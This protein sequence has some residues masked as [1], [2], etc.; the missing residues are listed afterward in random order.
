MD[1]GKFQ[2]SRE[3]FNVFHP[4]SQLIRQ[5]LENP[6]LMGLISSD[7]LLDP[8]EKAILKTMEIVKSKDL[9]VTAATISDLLSQAQDGQIAVEY[10]S[11]IMRA[12]YERQLDGEYLARVALER[13]N[14]SVLTKGYV[15]LG[16]ALRSKEYTSEEMANHFNDEIMIKMVSSTRSEDSAAAVER[17]YQQITDLQNGVVVPYWRTGS[18]KFDQIVAIGPHKIIMVAAAKKIGKSRFVIDRAMRLLNVNKGLSVVWFTFEMRPEEVIMNQIAWQT[19][20][21]TRKLQG[22]LGKMSESEI[23]MISETKAWI[24]D[25]PIRWI[26]QRRTMDQIEKDLNKW[27]KGPTMVIIDNLGLIEIPTGMN[28]IQSDDLIAKRMVN[29]RDSMDLCIIPIHHL[30]KASEDKTSRDDLYKP[31]PTH[32]RGSSRLVD[33]ANE[34]LLLHRPGHYKDLKDRFT[35]PDWEAIQDKFEVDVPINRDGPEGEIIFKHD[36]ATSTFDEL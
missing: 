1:P 28:D 18:D 33:Y 21:D 27:A 22:K 26:N 30:S 23:N 16:D 9:P 5:L 14:I 6:N 10:I 20:I 34:L 19:G 17:A 2:R 12:T 29:M 7:Q 15:F 24:K 31:K 13:Y 35:A 8:M 32:V 25:M 4:M 36:L 11:D 3:P